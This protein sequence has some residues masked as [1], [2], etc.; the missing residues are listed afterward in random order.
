MK[1]QGG[2]FT[3]LYGTGLNA[4][5]DVKPDTKER[6]KQIKRQKK[7]RLRKQATTETNHFA[8]VFMTNKIAA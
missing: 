4:T 7:R 6:K 5:L 1:R 2:I 8:R 3:R